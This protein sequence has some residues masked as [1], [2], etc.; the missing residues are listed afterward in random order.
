MGHIFSTRL[1]LPQTGFKEVLIKPLGK[2][3]LAEAIRGVLNENESE[4]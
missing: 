4:G 3:E 2:Y 1:E